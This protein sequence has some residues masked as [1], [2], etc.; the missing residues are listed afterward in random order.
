MIASEPTATAILLAAIGLLLAIS[1]ASSRA[2]ARLGLPL[3][4]VFIVIGMLAGSEGI[5]RIGFEDYHLTYRP[6]P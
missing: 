6:A 4:L 2:S 5:G 3:S 1:V